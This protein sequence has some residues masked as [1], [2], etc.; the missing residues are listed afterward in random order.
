MA[1]TKARTPPPPPNNDADGA[2]SS[3]SASGPAS[4][5]VAR[6]PPPPPQTPQTPQTQRDRRQQ[7]LAAAGVSP[8]PGGGDDGEVSRLSQAFAI[9]LV[10]P[11][12]AGIA[13]FMLL[14]LYSSG[15]LDAY[16]LPLLRA[17]P[18]NLLTRDVPAAAVL[19]AAAHAFL[20]S[21]LIATVLKTASDVGF[22]N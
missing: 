2:S 9:A 1:K 20:L 3:T 18:L 13:A 8:V 15:V 5:P 11:V 6:P 14:Q 4:S 10:F 16:L 19:A 7:L 21:P 17:K 12:I 22:D